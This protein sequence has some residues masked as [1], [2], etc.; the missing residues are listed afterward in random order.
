[1]FAPFRVLMW[2]APSSSILFFILTIAFQSICCHKTVHYVKVLW[3]SYSNR[4]S[5]PLLHRP[6]INSGE[7]LALTIF[8]D[9][10]GRIPLVIILALALWTSFQGITIFTFQSHSSSIPIHFPKLESLLDSICIL[11]KAA[12]YLCN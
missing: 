11:R 3:I 2:Y 1:M 5:I 4:Y 10:Q 7:T 6:H 12:V 9:S 8:A